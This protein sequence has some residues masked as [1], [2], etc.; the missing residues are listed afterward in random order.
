MLQFPYWHNSADPDERE[1][2]LAVA[3]R[4]KALAPDKIIIIPDTSPRLAPR[5]VQFVDALLMPSLSE[6]Q[7]MVVLEALASGVPVI[8][9]RATPFYEELQAS[10]SRSG[11]CAFVDLPERCRTGGTSIDRLEAHELA[12]VTS[13]LARLIEGI[14][15]LSDAERT[16]IADSL[17]NKYVDSEMYRAWTQVYGQHERATALH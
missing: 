10:T 17:P 6:V 4:L 9:T 3:R 11:I 14:S 8:G 1:R 15:T 7:P 5:P 13:K 16:A 12:E 2:A